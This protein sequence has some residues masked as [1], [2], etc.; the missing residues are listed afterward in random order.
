MPQIQITRSGVHPEHAMATRN[1]VFSLM[2]WPR[3]Q[4]AAERAD[5]M[6]TCDA[7]QVLDQARALP[8]TLRLEMLEQAW[9]AKPPDDFQAEIDRRVILGAQVGEYT[10]FSGSPPC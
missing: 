2:L 4:E 7:A 5:F 8:G 1:Y 6:R 3:E 9:R 10:R